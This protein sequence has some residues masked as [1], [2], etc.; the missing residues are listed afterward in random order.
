MK[1]PEFIGLD[2]GYS[3]IKMAQI[4][5]EQNNVPKLM[6]IGHSEIAKPLNILKDEKEK[7][8]LAD[9]IRTLK[10]TL[11]IKTNKCVVALPESMIFSKIIAVPDLPEDQLEKI[12]YFEARNHLPIPVEDVNLD[13]IPVAKK[14]VDNRSIQQI[15]MIAAP[16]NIINMYL[17]IINLAGLEPLALETESLATAR[18][19]TYKLDMAQGALVVDFGSKNIAV[20]IIKGKNVIFSQSI[21]TGSD[22]LTQAIARDYNIDLRQA[23]QYKITYGLLQS[24]LEGKIAKSLLPVMQIINNELNK[25]INFIKINLPDFA[26]SEMLLV[27]EG[28][29]LPGLVTFFNLNLGIPVKLVDPFSILEISDMAKNEVANLSKPAFTVAIGLALKVE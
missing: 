1:L 14:S 20:S 3:S 16:K 4:I 21:G 15:L 9:R 24:Q 12:I 7:K 25:I 22:A 5:F 17:E 27:G 13:H 11:Q 8:E 18:A 26:P 28:S 10:D 19:M 29:L 2:I 6:G 23:E